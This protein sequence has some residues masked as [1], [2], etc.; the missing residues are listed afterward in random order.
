VK[1]TNYRHTLSS[2]VGR[3]T[4]AFDLIDNTDYEA[5]NTKEI[6]LIDI[7]KN[8]TRYALSQNTFF[9][10]K[11]ISHYFPSIESLSNFIDNTEFLAGLEVTFIG[12]T[13]RL[14]EI[15]N[16]D[17]LQAL[18]GLLQ[19]IES[20]I[21]SNT[22]EYQGSEYVKENIYKV[23]KDKEIKVKKDSERADGQQT[24]IANEPW[25]AYNANYGTSEEKSFVRL[26]SSRFT[27]INQKFEDIYLIRNEREVKIYDNSGRAFEPDFLLFCKQKEE[28]QYTYQV[29]IEPKGNHLIGHDKWKEDYL[30]EIRN[31]KKVIEISTDKYLLTAVPFY[32][33]QNENEFKKS[34]NEVLDITQS[35]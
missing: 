13:N 25:Y 17:Y 33:Y 19:S 15:S 34:L 6:K 21:K 27:S 12:T 9:Y 22:T 1:K 23:F 35:D 8:I 4:G 30:K 29:F 11:N 10:F 28:N 2:G 20:D 3:V 16:Y 7:P 5:I 18:Q 26:F 24:L 31:D 14:E 32:N